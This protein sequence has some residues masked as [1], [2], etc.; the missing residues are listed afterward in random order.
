VTRADMLQASIEAHKGDISKFAALIRA[1]ISPLGADPVRSKK[2]A[3][4]T[5]SRKR[6]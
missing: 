6:P 1:N 3:V 4:R 2:K 5:R